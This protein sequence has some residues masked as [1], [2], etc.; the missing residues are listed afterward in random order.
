MTLRVRL[1]RLGILPCLST[2]RSDRPVFGLTRAHH[3]PDLTLVGTASRVM[4]AERA[5]VAV[6]A[7]GV[8]T[9]ANKEADRQAQESSEGDQI[10][11]DLNMGRLTDCA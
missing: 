2:L 8:C 10:Q 11:G 4:R 1:T 9:V 3:F 6:A 5:A 7:I